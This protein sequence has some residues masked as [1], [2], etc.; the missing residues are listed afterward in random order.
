MQVDIMSRALII[1]RD[2]SRS[3][4]MEEI[5]GPAVAEIALIDLAFSDEEWLD[6]QV[7]TEYTE[8]ALL[9]E[10]FDTSV[11]DA[12]MALEATRA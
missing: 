11:I 7:T 2:P 6:E 9:L 1:D 8:P 3:I 5:T 10:E 12:L 4:I